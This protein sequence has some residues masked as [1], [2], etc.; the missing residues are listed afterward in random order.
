MGARRHP[1]K[2]AAALLLVLLALLPIGGASAVEPDEVLQDAKLEARARRLSAELRC[3]VCQNQSID[4]SNAPLAKDLRLIVR[5][6]LLAG[7][8]N[9]AVLDFIVARYGTFVLL[10][11]P[12]GLDTILLWTT[13]LVVLSGIGIVLALHLRRR[14]AELTSVGQ[15]TGTLSP[16][17]QARLD[18][19]LRDRE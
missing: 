13:P 4:D 10:R 11:P 7:D 8:S 12:L 16:E 15:S 2:L 17:E 19:I 18:E 5:E 6:R 14:R 1:V 3:L 9:D